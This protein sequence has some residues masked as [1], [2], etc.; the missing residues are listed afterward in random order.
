VAAAAG[1]VTRWLLVLAVVLVAG[2][3]GAAWW[4]ASAAD[5]VTIDRIGDS[6]Q[7]RARGQL[8]TFVD[9]DDVRALY[10]FAAEHPALVGAMPCVCGCVDFGHT[11]NRACYIK[12]ETPERVT[13]TSH[14]AT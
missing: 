3:G 5:P 8:P 1:L 6:V 13:W 7:T 10:R 2:G 9:G 12:A 14:A 11:S 4:M